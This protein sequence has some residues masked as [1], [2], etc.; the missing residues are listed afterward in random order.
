MLG[1]KD[2]PGA[3]SAMI[4]MSAPIDAFFSEVMVMAEDIGVR[5]NR[6]ALLKAIANLT[7]QIA[8]I[9]KIVAV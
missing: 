5:S 6:L 1:V 4:K 3:L 8:D 2:Y 7:G 9:S